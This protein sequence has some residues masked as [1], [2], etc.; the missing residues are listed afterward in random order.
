M[1]FRKSHSILPLLLILAVFAGSVPAAEA[2]SGLTSPKQEFGFDVGADYQLIN[3]AKL[4]AYWRKLDGQSDRMS[5]V[6]IGRSSEG[7]PMIM[8]IITSPGNQRR[9]E[10]YKSIA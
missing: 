9:L 4:S 1:S 5:L 6:E 8:A 2:Q 10:R 3:Y 7:R